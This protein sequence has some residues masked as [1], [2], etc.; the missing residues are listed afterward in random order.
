MW[1]RRCG[2]PL[3]KTVCL[4][5]EAWPLILFP[6]AEGLSFHALSNMLTSVRCIITNCP[7]AYW[8]SFLPALLPALLNTLLERL[9][10]EWAHMIDR[11]LVIEQEDEENPK[12]E[13][14]SDEMMEECL[15]RHFSN[16]AVRLVRDLCSVSRPPGVDPHG[17]P[18]TTTLDM[19]CFSKP[20]IASPLIRLILFLMSVR[21]Q[22]SSG[23]AIAA[24][25][26]IVTVVGAPAGPGRDIEEQMYADAFRTILYML[27]DAYF[28][29][30]H[31]T[32]TMI[33]VQLYLVADSRKSAA[34]RQVLQ[35]I[36]SLAADDKVAQFHETFM[37]TS[38]KR[39]QKL[40][41]WALV[42][43][44]GINDRAINGAE[45]RKKALA[46]LGVADVD[47]KEILRRFKS[48][49]RISE[50]DGRGSSNLV[51]QADTEEDVG[52]SGLFGPAAD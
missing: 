20:A 7:A 2:T 28:S 49:L 1:Q 46:R 3:H 44:S 12:E 9:R 27:N 33:L 6:L 39:S 18:T 17:L 19:F 48:G 34:C 42:Q 40:I 24:L 35:S 15:L 43:S 52:L 50:Q 29:A 11:G 38:N 10:V 14:L 26:S 47:S 32:L 21:D 13:D 30:Q 5:C 36:P 23:V 8:P 25:K 45:D 31:S 22:R 4:L 16:S 41:M 37:R 51:E